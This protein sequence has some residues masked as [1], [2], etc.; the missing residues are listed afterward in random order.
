MNTPPSPPPSSPVQYAPR[1]APGPSGLAITG[2]VFGVLG[3]VGVCFM[4]AVVLSLVGLVLSLIAVRQPPRGLA[5]AGIVL[6]AIGSAWVLL[7]FVIF[8]LLAGVATVGA[9][10]QGP[11]GTVEVAARPLAAAIETWQ[12]DRGT[13]PATVVELISAGVL[14]EPPTDGFGSPLRFVRSADGQRFEIRSAGPDLEPGTADDGRLGSVPTL[15]G[16]ATSG[17]RGPI[18]ELPDPDGGGP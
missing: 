17:G 5:I 1:A 12:D 11:P 4:P 6:G 7:F 3:L 10:V 15:A 16:R 2:F 9:V 8:V 14:T 13:D 18:I